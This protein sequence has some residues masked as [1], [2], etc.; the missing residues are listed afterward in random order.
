MVIEHKEWRATLS[1]VN[2]REGLNQ[3]TVIS[4]IDEGLW[5]GQQRGLGYLKWQK[6][7]FNI[8]Y[9]FE[10]KNDEDVPF[11]DTKLTLLHLAVN[12]NLENIVN[13]LLGVKGINVN[14]LDNHNRTSLHYAFLNDYQ[15]IIEALLTN[16]ANVNSANK[17]GETPL[18]W[19]AQ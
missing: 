15:K 8:S 17:V 16:K 5:N 18:H 12:F 1:A 14:A 10:V 9:L 7:N 11:R 13:S 4:E 19:A 2:G 6:D 3:N